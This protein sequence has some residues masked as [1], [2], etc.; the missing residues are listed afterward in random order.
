M[1][2]LPK[3]MS[4]PGIA[5][6]CLISSIAC[7]LSACGGDGGANST[8]TILAAS[9][10]QAVKTQLSYDVIP[11]SLGGDL[12][13][14]HVSNKGISPNG[15]VAGFTSVPDGPLH[16]FVYDGQKMIDLGTFGGP[17]S[18]AWA[19]N[20]CGNVVGSAATSDQYRHAFLYDGTMHDLG[21][22]G[23]PSSEALDISACG[24]VTGWANT[25]SGPEHA[26]LY[27]KGVM[28]DLGTLAGAN[29]SYGNAVNARGQVTGYSGI[30]GNG[31]HAFLYTNG[32]MIDLGA[33]DGDISNGKDINEAG[34]VI[35]QYRGADGQ[36]H[37]FIYDGKAMSDLGTLGALPGVEFVD[38][39]AINEAG[40]VTGVAVTAGGLTHAFIYDGK[41]MRDLDPGGLN[42][43]RA[44]DINE[45]DQV[46]GT[47]L[48]AG[49]N[50]EHAMTWLP[51]GEMIDL[52]TRIPRAPRGLLLIEGLSVADNGAIVARANTG[53]VLLRPVHSGQ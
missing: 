14:P 29:F 13:V 4:M 35:G 52:N 2:T 48:F 34:K 11:L 26:F 3:T 15:K 18:R 41:Q 10:D 53:L 50:T 49:G 20:Q 27:E 39:V 33:L 42:F 30:S 17:D 7:L 37:G 32:A 19:I 36:T 31:F 5:R 28:K 40:H 9:S 44:A 24:K 8:E 38:P 23:G 21:T 25:A 12:F 6:L 46:V 43:S 22:L 47:M 51:S 1:L 16:A 45:K